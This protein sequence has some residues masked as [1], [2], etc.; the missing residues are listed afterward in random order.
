M[1]C[2]PP[3]VSI[4]AVPLM[5]CWTAVARSARC[6]SLSGL[7]RSSDFFACAA[8]GSR[9]VGALAAW[10]GICRVE[11]ASAVTA[12][13]VKTRRVRRFIGFSWVLGHAIVGDEVTFTDNSQVVNPKIVRNS[14]F[15]RTMDPC[16]G[17][18]AL[19]CDQR[20]AI[21]EGQGRRPLRAGGTTGRRGGLHP[22]VPQHGRRPGRARLRRRLVGGQRCWADPRPRPAV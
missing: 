9:S 21:R 22:C 5:T 17:G 1:T 18:R 16:G 10:A 14:T 7:L 19:A 13:P 6:L 12:T 15:L 20:V 2:W 11:T 8:A 4:L 3:L